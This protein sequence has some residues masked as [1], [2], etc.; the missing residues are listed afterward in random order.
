MSGACQFQ[1][2]FLDHW[3]DGIDI[4][5]GIDAGAGVYSDPLFG[6]QKQTHHLGHE[7][8]YSGV[9]FGESNARLPRS[10][11]IEVLLVAILSVTIQPVIPDDVFP[12]ERFISIAFNLRNNFRIG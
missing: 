12:H 11:I 6:L 8:F 1:N 4:Y 2:Y 7:V 5:G 3:C 9:S 10:L